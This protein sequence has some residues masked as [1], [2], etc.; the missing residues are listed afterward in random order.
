VHQ[1]P[2]VPVSPTPMHE[3]SAEMQPRRQALGCAG[4]DASQLPLRSRARSG[5]RCPGR[6]IFEPPLLARTRERFRRAST[7]I[8]HA[9]RERFFVIFASSALAAPCAASLRELVL[10]L[11]LVPAGRASPLV[12]EACH[13]SL[14]QTVDPSAPQRSRYAQRSDCLH[15][16]LRPPPRRL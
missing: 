9:S 4:L 1:P 14:L 5:A 6:G 11:V 10:V 13:P 12:S 2:A 3:A 15:R 8:P 7:R 16:K